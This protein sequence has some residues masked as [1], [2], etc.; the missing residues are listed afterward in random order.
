MPKRQPLPAIPRERNKP[1]AETF[2]FMTHT[3][4]SDPQQSPYAAIGGKPVLEALTHRFYELM[5]TQAEAQTIRRMH[6]D[7]LSSSRDKL[8]MFLSGWLGGP[9]LY[10]KA[11]GHPFLRARHLPFRIGETERDAWLDCMKQA[12]K[13]HVANA[14][15]REQ[16][17]D[18]FAKL[19][20]HM[21]NQ[22]PR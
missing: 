9:P 20:D 2:R 14:S 3:S 16:L 11:Y 4:Q 7:D 19:A 21:R 5:D 10:V 17:F 22:T 18:A 8:F 6:P 1:E 13:E 15:L 12:L